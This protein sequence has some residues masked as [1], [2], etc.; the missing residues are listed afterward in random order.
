MTHHHSHH[1][2]SEPVLRDPVCGMTV[3]PE[4]GKPI[5]EHDGRIFHFCGSRCRE[6][7]AAAP[8]DYLEARDPVCGMTVDRAAARHMAKHEGRRFYF[9]S[10]G[11]RKKFEAAPEKYLEDVA[12]ARDAPVGA[13]WTCPMHP[14]I[15]RDGP[16]DCPICGM[17]L[18]PVMPSA[19]TG[20]N[21]E[22]VDFTRRF[23]A[24]L[25][26]TL[27]LLVLA[28]G[29]HLG[30]PLPHGLMGPSGRWLELALASPVVLW[31]GWPFFK[32]AWASVQNVSP[33]MWTL[34]GLGTGTAYGFSAVA[35]VVPGLF[36][37][38]FRDAHGSVGVYFESA[39]VIVVLVLLGQLMEL[40]ARERTS[41]AIRALLDLAPKR[42]RRVTQSGEEDTA[43]E[44][45]AVGDRLRVRPGDT[46]PVD[47]VVEEGHSS[48]DE[49]MLTGE[50]LPVEKAPG[51]PVTG[52]T[53]NQSG[54]FIMRAERV[55]ADTALSRIVSLV[56]EAQRSRAPVQG[57]ADR[58]AAWFVPAVVAIGVLAFAAWALWG[59]EPPLAHALVALVTVLIIACPCALGLATPMSIMVA[60]GR[61]ARSG[62]LIRNAEALEKLAAV[63]TLIVDKTGTLTLGKP[64]LTDIHPVGAFEAE[65]L[66]ALAASLEAQSEHPLAAAV[67]AAA[68]EKAV[69]LL[70]VED[71]SAHVGEGISGT[72]D[73]KRVAIGNARLLGRLGIDLAPLQ[74]EPERLGRTGATV[75][76]IAVDG[77]A[78]GLLSISD[79]VREEAA[80]SLAALKA[81]G[82]RIIVATG[83][84]GPAAQAVADKL[85]LEDVRAGLKPSDKAELIHRLKADGAKVAMAGDGINDAP[86]L[87]AAD[88]GIAMET[89]SDV[90][91]ESAGV[92]LLGG[93]L[94]G[95]VR[96][97]RLARLTLANIR[98]N[99]A[100][101]FLY[102]ALGV[103]LAAGVLYPAFGLVLSPA[104]AAAA[105]SL[106]S[107]SVIA[108]ALRLRTQRL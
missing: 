44:D 95:L 58:V 79:P 13:T 65:E 74:A 70:P 15:V 66:L 92:M 52:G 105:M 24:G 6:K 98:Q 36:P 18:E 33:N 71:F 43:L 31:C 2:H 8:E 27:P 4:A 20:P 21:P 87:A 89:G 94:G 82:L 99:L 91:V 1:H 69:A 64:T 63:E 41:D 11:C 39:A 73:G 34:I 85:G 54:S 78:A 84:A 68:R 29:P 103:P 75:V 60:T 93:D 80:R 77:S 56:A 19:E 88:V 61:G 46:V 35:T 97:R 9:C 106:S 14:E 7:F 25:I 22:L 40:K 53:G 3:D 76:H 30:L 51:A 38:A 101:A 100:F 83:D 96:A 104:F 5:H 55:G 57:L 10:E 107:V 17:A 47:G 81:E 86:A 42:T 49:S 59:P 102:N 45:V 12:Q 48:V 50:P 37:A 90:A 62:L 26:F 108:N 23:W 28:M 16:G 32:R 72:V 67:T